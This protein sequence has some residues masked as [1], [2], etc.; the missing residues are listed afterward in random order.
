MAF[1]NFR[2]NVA[3]RALLLVI[4]ISVSLWGWIGEHWLVTPVVA[5]LLAIL[6]VA[7]LIWYV[8]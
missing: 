4:S 3:A 6:Q 5:G 8:N 2:A 1:S 7:E